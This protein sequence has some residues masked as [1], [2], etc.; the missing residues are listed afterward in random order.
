MATSRYTAELFQSTLP[1]R[2]ATT[3]SPPTDTGAPISIHA[4]REGSDHARWARL[5]WMA[6]FQSTLPARGAT[7][8]KPMFARTRRLFQSTLP[9]RGATTESCTCLPVHLISIH[10]P[11]EGSDSCMS[12]VLIEGLHFNP[13]SPRGE[14]RTPH[15]RECY[16]PDF[17]PRSPR[18]ERRGALTAETVYLPISIHA[19]REGSDVQLSQN[20]WYQ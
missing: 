11:R 19:P 3:V 8:G 6:Q 4:P 2:G 15:L 1:A 5:V 18:G 17:N 10:A 20:C 7:A 13:R 16:H 12:L 14:R 9:A